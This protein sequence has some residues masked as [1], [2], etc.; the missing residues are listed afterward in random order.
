MK[1]PYHVYATTDSVGNWDGQE[2][3]A[4]ANINRIYDV[5]YAR[6]ADD[7]DHDMLN[8]IVHNVWDDWGTDIYLLDITDDIINEYVDYVLK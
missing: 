6:A 8:E 7:I 3:L 2:A 1:T 5:I 4:A